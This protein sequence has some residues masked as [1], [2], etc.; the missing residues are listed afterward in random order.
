[1]K[2]FLLITLVTIAT[3]CSSPSSYK[4]TRFPANLAADDDC[5]EV[6]RAFIDSN[7]VKSGP[8]LVGQRSLGTK[9]PSFDTFR[10]D[11]LNKRPSIDNFVKKYRADNNGQAPK[12]A[13]ALVFFRDA[14]LD[15]TS[16]IRS[17]K[18]INDELDEYLE[19][20]AS[21]IELGP[22]KAA[23]LDGYIADDEFASLR[24]EAFDISDSNQ[25][26]L[27]D[28]L[29]WT[30]YKGHLGELDVLLRLEDLQAQSVYLTKTELLNPK[31]Q[32]VND[33]LSSALEQKLAALDI[34]QIPDLKV[35]FPKVFKDSGDLSDEEILSKAKTFLETKEFDLIVKKHGRYSIVEVKN[36]KHPISMS[37]M[38][39]D[40]GNKKTILDQQLETVQIIQ[41]LGLDQKV[42]PS[43]AF[44]RGVKADAKAKL[45]SHG[46]SVLAE[47]V[48]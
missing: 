8:I 1:M 43:V 18:G 3:S 37:D 30:N 14:H 39:V 48:D 10:S 19:M 5:Y 41:F 45:E 16:H 28:S 15:L 23:K 40:A 9:I 35:K 34:S 22:S 12:L 17:A 38:R 4:L 27:F 33:L 25:R 26:Q 47:I 46:I 13:Q 20:S 11:M 29:G 32:E 42:F 6:A 24:N 44:L 2:Y 31:S 21:H 7:P 36:Y